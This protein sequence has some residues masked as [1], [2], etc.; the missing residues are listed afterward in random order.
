MAL[1]ASKTASCTI[2]GE[3]AWKKGLAGATVACM[4]A[5][6]SVTASACVAAG[7]Y[8]AQA[9]T[10]GMPSRLLMRFIG[11]VLSLG[12]E[13]PCGAPAPRRSASFA[14]RRQAARRLPSPRSVVVQDGRRGDPVVDGRAHGIRES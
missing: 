5:F 12:K 8:K 6:Q 14:S 4:I 9:A 3:R 13:S 7:A 1:T 10:M 2:A 11:H